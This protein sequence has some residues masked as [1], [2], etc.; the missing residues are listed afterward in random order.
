M[1]SLASSLGAEMIFG[2]HGAQAMMLLEKHQNHIVEVQGNYLEEMLDPV[3]QACSGDYV[4]RLDDDERCSPGLVEWLR[5][6]EMLKRD[7]WFFSRC[8]LW[9]DI[10][11]VLSE[12]PYFPD[13]QARVS[14]KRQAR[15][16][17]RIHAPHV[18]PAYR[19]PASAYLEHHVF[20]TKT[21]A[22][23]QVITARYETIRTGKEFL[24]EQVTYAFPY[25]ELN[26]VVEPLGSPL[27]QRLA[28]DTI[29]WRQ[30]GQRLPSNLDQE[31]KTWRAN[32]PQ[33]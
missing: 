13:F 23:R 1:A 21:R 33:G 15:R 27:L 24:P 10:Q 20:L 4:L 30:V 18:Y 22:D 29:W 11:H 7:S 31:L 25:D 5:S 12:Q 32:N 17:A 2:V 19:A 6:D 8:H 26:P 16:P 28:E 14:V 3:I 9:P